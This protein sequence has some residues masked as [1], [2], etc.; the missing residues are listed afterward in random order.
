MSTRAVLA[1]AR[2]Q[3]DGAP[4]EGLGELVVPRRVLGIGRSARIVPRGQAWHLGALL[5]TDDGVLATGEILRAR[6]EARRGFAAES[7]R[8]RAELAAAARR[9]G[10]AE[11]QTVHIGWTTLDPDAVDRG[12]ASGPLALRDDVPSIRWSAAGGF[13]P[14]ERYLAER[15]ELL[16]HPPTGAS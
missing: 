4:R 14:L 10:F 12:S 9:G 16:Q 15:I 2:A 5:L 7:Q 6:T 11:G 1:H 13:M 8:Q 3:L